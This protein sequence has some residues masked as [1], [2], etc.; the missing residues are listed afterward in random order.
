MNVLT[1][2]NNKSKF[3]FIILLI[4]LWARTKVF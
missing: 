4:A 2:H 1:F 3:D